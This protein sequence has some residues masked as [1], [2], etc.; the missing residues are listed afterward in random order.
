MIEHYFTSGTATLVILSLMALE[1]IILSRLL[2]RIPAIAWGLLAGA[3][4][5]LALTASMMQYG[6]EII[7]ALLALSFVFHLVEVRQWLKIAKQ[8]PA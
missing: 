5:V 2:K 8:L 1:A 7:G 6:F 3:T 4:M